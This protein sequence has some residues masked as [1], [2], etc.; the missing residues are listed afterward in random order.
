ML[1]RSVERLKQDFFS[2]IISVPES[3]PFDANSDETE[4]L[5]SNLSDFISSYL[6]STNQKITS[7]LKESSQGVCFINSSYRIEDEYSNMMSSFFE[8]ESL[9]GSSVLAVLKNKITPKNIENLEEYLSLMF[10]PDIDINDLDEMNPLKQVEF[11]IQNSDGRLETKLLKF[12]FKRIVEKNRI[13]Y[14]TIFIN[15]IK[16]EKELEQ[17]LSYKDEELSKQLSIFFTL[18]TID[19]IQFEH[20]LEELTYEIKNIH[21]CLQDTSTSESEKLNSLANSTSYIAE[22]SKALN[23]I[24]LFDQ[25]V[26]LDYTV[27]TLKMNGSVQPNSFSPFCI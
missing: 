21:S 1:F 15:D 12:D 2:H 25:I 16:Q 7:L 24:E 4:M 14:L 20:F 6:T 10:K 27:Q 11:T 19:P 8:K 18:M 3:F 13:K 26:K 22:Y 9:Q 17:K 5:F 23:V